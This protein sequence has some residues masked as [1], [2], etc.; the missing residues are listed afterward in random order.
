MKYCTYILKDPSTDIPFYV[1]SGAL[2]RPHEHFYLYKRDKNYNKKKKIKT[3]LLL[4]S[5]KDIV[6]IIEESNDRYEMFS[7]EQSYLDEYKTIKDGGILYNICNEVE[8]GMFGIKMSDEQKIKMSEARKGKKLSEETKKKI[9]EAGKGRIVSNVTR[10]KLS[11][12]NKGKKMSNES[13]IKMSEARKGKKRGMFSEETR[14]RMSEACKGKKRGIPSEET[15]SKMV[16]SQK[17]R[18][19]NR[20]IA[21]YCFEAT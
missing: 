6:E 5:E 1:G 8:R 16:A 18:W 21:N 4:F 11:K 2:S 12:I 9:G 7:L 10:Q 19:I 15:K 14:R 17:I 3:L 20:R 13:K